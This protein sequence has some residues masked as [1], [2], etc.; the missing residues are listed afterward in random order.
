MT[1]PIDA[2]PT[3]AL[4]LNPSAELHAAVVCQQL[5]LRVERCMAGALDCSLPSGCKALVCDGEPFESTEE[6]LRAVRS[7]HPALPVIL[8]VRLAHGVSSLLLAA[9][10]IPDVTVV[11]QG[12]AESQRLADGLQRVL[13]SRHELAVADDVT[14]RLPR[15][16]VRPQR[17][18]HEVLRCRASGERC[19]VRSVSIAIGESARRVLDTWPRE[20]LPRPK[21][22]L[23][24]LTLLYVTRVN[25]TTGAGWEPI[26]HTLGVDG[27]YLRRLRHRYFTD[28]STRLTYDTAILAFETVIHSDVY[29]R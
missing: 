5:N 21:E 22:Y 4:Q 11:E 7:R 1:F 8:F 12:W 13:R 24:W 2:T 18:T 20:M 25:E 14:R 6:R 27:S 16:S 29:R 10:R 3:V 17:F 15:L 19:T 26:A 23:D 9:S 28:R